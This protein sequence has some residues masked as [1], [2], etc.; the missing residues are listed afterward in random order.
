MASVAPF[1]PLAGPIPK[2]GRVD[3]S[4]PGST[5]AWL[6]ATLGRRVGKLPTT[7][8]NARLLLG[9]N[10]RSRSKGRVIL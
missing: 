9:G 8:T 10:L 4:Q 7:V 5:P 6:D 3:T 1:Q 2:L